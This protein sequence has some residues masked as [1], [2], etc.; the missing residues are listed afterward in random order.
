MLCPAAVAQ[1][2]PPLTTAQRIGGVTHTS[3]YAMSHISEVFSLVC[4]CIGAQ[5]GGETHTSVY[6]MSHKREVSLT[7]LC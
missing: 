5:K 2:Q 1:W 6:T 4:A 3:V 7:R